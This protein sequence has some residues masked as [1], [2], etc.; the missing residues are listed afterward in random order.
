MGFVGLG[1]LSWLPEFTYDIK[2]GLIEEGRCV[3]HLWHSLGCGSAPSSPLQHRASY[4]K[5]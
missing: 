3:V 4:L 5:V 2:S 1:K